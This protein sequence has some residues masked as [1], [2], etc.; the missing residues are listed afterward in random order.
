MT[1]AIPLPLAYA[2]FAFRGSGT[3]VPHSHAGTALQSSGVISPKFPR[4]RVLMEPASCC[5]AY[6]QYGNELSAAMW[7]TCSVDWLYHEL[8]VLPPSSVTVAPWSTPNSIRLALVGSSHTCCGSSP[9]GAPLKPV[10][11][12][13]PSVDT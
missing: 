9:P 5:V 8:H 6:T 13:P 4:L 12:L 10:N 2:V 7:Y 11:V 1:F 3:M